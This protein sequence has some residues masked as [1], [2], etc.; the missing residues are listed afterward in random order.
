MDRNSPRR[1]LKAAPLKLLGSIALASA[2]AAL[3][4]GCSTAT[5]KPQKNG[6]AGLF[7]RMKPGKRGAHASRRPSQEPDSPQLLMRWPLDDVQ[8][9]STYGKRGRDFHEGVDLRAKLGTPVF[10]SQAGTV[11]Y[12]DKRIKGYGKMIVVR[13]SPGWATVYAHNSKLFVKEG[14]KVQKGQRIA[15]SGK[16]GR[17]SGPHLHF[18]IRNGL[19]AVDPIRMLPKARVIASGGESDVPPVAIGAGAAA[20]TASN[21][22]H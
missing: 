18:E 21:E 19:S 3:G 13:H 7:D 20:V 12:S 22:K 9:T 4:T 11:L 6:R 1:N 10:A 14:Q 17:V 2:L 5:I 16:S 8:I 15:L